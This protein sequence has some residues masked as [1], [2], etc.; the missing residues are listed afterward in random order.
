MLVP[1]PT[2]GPSMAKGLGQRAAHALGDRR[3]GVGVVERRQHDH[4]SVAAQARQGA[5]PTIRRQPR[6]DVAD[7]QLFLQARRHLA[8]QGV[9]GAVAEGVVD[10]L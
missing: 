2:L 6:D 5:G 4:E 1:M 3:R 8:Q 7:P 10:A 9:A